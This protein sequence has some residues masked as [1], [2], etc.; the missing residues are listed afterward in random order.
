MI[1]HEFEFELPR[2]GDALLPN[3][4]IAVGSFA[5]SVIDRARRVVDIL[6]GRLTQQGPL[7]FDHQF[8]HI[9]A[10]ADGPPLA[11][12]LKKFGELT[13]NKLVFLMTERYVLSTFDPDFTYEG[14]ADWTD[15][16]YNLEREAAK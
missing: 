2:P 6:G 12:W 7:E 8:L 10:E 11:I 16:L 5:L 3:P 13:A 9:T 14:F 15:Y 1:S 4:P